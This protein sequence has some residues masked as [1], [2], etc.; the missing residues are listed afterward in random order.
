MKPKMGRPKLPKNKTKGVLIGARFSPEEAKQ[1]N[2]F[3][4]RSTEGK[5]EWIRNTLLSATKVSQ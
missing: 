4:H 1:V 3:A 5:S 2:D